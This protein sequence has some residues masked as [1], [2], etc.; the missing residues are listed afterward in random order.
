MVE[1]TRFGRYFKVA[2]DRSVHYG[3][4]DCSPA[5]GGKPEEGAC[6]GCSCC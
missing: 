3:P 1:E 2:G 5:P 6:G 4:F